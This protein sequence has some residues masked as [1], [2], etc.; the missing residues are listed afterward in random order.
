M[1]QATPPFR[2]ILR[3]HVYSVSGNTLVKFEVRSFNQ[4]ELFAFNDAAH[5]HTDTSNENS[6]STIHSVH[7]AEIKIYKYSTL[8]KKW[9]NE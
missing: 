3:S 8:A 6:I 7:L 5:R 2:K 4:L 1:T 9:H